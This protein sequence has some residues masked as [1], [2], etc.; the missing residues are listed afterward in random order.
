MKRIVIILC[1][2][3]L[4]L[5]S[6]GKIGLSAGAGISY[7]SQ[8]YPGY[9]PL[10]RV[11][12][13]L[14]SIVNWS[15]NDFFSMNFIPEYRY[16]TRGVMFNLYSL[17]FGLRLGQLFFIEVNGYGGY[18]EFKNNTTSI[19]SGSFIFYPEAG[20]GINIFD[21]VTLK[22]IARVYSGDNISYGALVSFGFGL[23]DVKRIPIKK[24]VFK[25]TS[26][27]ILGDYNTLAP[28][29]VGYL[30]L[31]IQNN[32]KN[33]YNNLRL[34]ISSTDNNDIIVNNKYNQ[35][36]N[37]KPGDSRFFTLEL[38]ASKSG[39]PGIYTNEV[40]LI[41]GNITNLLDTVLIEI[42]NKEPKNGENLVVYTSSSSSAAVVNPDFSGF[43][44]AE[45]LYRKELSLIS[46]LKEHNPFAD[47]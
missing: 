5:S 38:T 41:D 16:G 22:G 2:L 18:A 14:N 36:L 12:A 17:G 1:F 13:C 27:L 25:M 32:G 7:S 37:Y 31:E 42:R 8:Y 44:S 35:G 39:K 29:E 28:G 43:S 30:T 15:L 40:N 6:Y 19:S 34:H 47:M 9:T 45:S 11:E 26:S 4:A 3:T 23:D 10:L 33:L 21:I 24:G 46:Q 20:A